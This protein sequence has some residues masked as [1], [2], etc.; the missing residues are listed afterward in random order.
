MTFAD[1]LAT[2]AVVVADDL[3]NLGNGIGRSHRL[4]AQ[5]AAQITAPLLLTPPPLPPPP[6]PLPPQPS[7]VVVAL[8]ARIQR[9]VTLLLRKF[10]DAGRRDYMTT[11]VNCG[12]QLIVRASRDTINLSIPNKRL[13]T[14]ARSRAA[15]PACFVFLPRSTAPSLRSIPS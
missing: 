4:A 12:E 3:S 11:V 15:A 9:F 6:P 13:R 1:P 8:D 2:R 7:A 5:L 14:D 10:V